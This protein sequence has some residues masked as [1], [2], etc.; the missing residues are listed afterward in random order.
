MYLLVGHCH[1]ELGLVRQPTVLQASE[2]SELSPSSKTQKR[3]FESTF[4][5]KMRSRTFSVKRFKRKKSEAKLANKE[6][7]GENP[8][9]TQFGGV[10]E[11]LPLSPFYWLSF[12]RLVGKT[13][14]SGKEALRST[15][16]GG[17]GI[18]WIRSKKKFKR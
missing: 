7:L 11:T 2:E 5:P 6:S 18:W 17:G 16:L 13:Q 1:K 15:I 9:V 4:T 10:T 8:L 3:C 14:I 12:Q